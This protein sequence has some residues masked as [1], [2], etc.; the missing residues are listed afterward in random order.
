MIGLSSAKQAVFLRIETCSSSGK[1]QMHADKSAK[2]IQSWLDPTQVTLKTTINVSDP[3]YIE[4]FEVWVNG[5]LVH[6]EQQGHHGYLDSHPCPFHKEAVRRA[7]N[8]CIAG[9]RTVMPANREHSEIKLEKRGRQHSEEMAMKRCELGEVIKTKQKGQVHMNSTKVPETE[10]EQQEDSPKREAS[11]EEE[12]QQ[13][14]AKSQFE[15]EQLDAVVDDWL[16]ALQRRFGPSIACGR[17]GF[18]SQ[19]Q[20]APV[21]WAKTEA[22]LATMVA[23]RPSAQTPDKAEL[24]QGSLTSSAGFH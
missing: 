8:D 9:T 2:L 11:P 12:T 17:K 20:S 10:R 19:A 1:F 13:A 3:K 21:S 24:P 14:K 23:S 22:S 7:I 18:K 16:Q 5:T 6:S 15:R 4:A